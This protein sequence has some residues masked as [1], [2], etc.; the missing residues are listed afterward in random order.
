M[1]SLKRAVRLGLSRPRR[2]AT[3][4]VTN[5]NGMAK[6]KKHPMKRNHLACQVLGHRG[7]IFLS[8]GIGLSPY[9]TLS[10]YPLSLFA[11]SHNQFEEILCVSVPYCHEHLFFSALSSS[12]GRR[13]LIATS[14]SPGSHHCLVS[15]LGIAS[16]LCPSGV[17][18]DFKRTD[19]EGGDFHSS[20]DTPIPYSFCF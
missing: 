11:C 10:I 18:H 5:T 8:S 4:E 2:H 1:R 15:L 3:N 14:C 17:C 7:G 13:R 6:M 9:T 16:T 20:P 12:A 19:V